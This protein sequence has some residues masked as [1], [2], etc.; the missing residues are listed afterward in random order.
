MVNNHWFPFNRFAE[1][2]LSVI[3]VMVATHAAVRLSISAP[4]MTVAIASVRIV[5][6][7]QNKE[8]MNVLL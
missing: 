1:L 3:I 7:N 5:F 2:T 8:S 4:P 6:E